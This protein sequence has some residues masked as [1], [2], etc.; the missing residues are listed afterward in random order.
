MRIAIDARK[1]RDY[2][3]VGLVADRERRRAHDRARLTDERAF[4]ARRLDA[5]R[6]LLRLAETDYELGDGAYAALAR[7]RL[8]VLEAEHA[9]VRCDHQLAALDAGLDPSPLADALPA[10]PDGASG[11]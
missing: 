5:Q 1:L 6:E 2:G 11:D 4:L 10:P 8:A 7:Q 3:I 9:L